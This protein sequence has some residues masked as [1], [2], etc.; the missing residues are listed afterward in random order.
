MIELLARLFAR[1]DTPEDRL[2]RVAIDAIVAGTDP[3]LRAVG[4][5]DKRLHEPARTAIRYVRDIAERLGPAVEL[6]AAIYGSDPRVHALFGSVDSMR[7]IVGR[8]PALRAFEREADRPRGDEVFA[9]LLAER[10]LKHVLG[11]DLHGDVVMRDLAKTLLV[12]AGHRLRAVAGS[13]AEARRALRILAFRQLVA[14][15]RRHIDD[16]R[17]GRP[18]AL[19]AGAAD[20]PA[21][22]DIAARLRQTG[23]SAL[24]LADYL[25]L[26]AGVFARP[27]RQLQARMYSAVVDRMGALVEGSNTRSD[28]DA[29]AFWEIQ[30]ADQDAPTVALRVRLRPEDFPP[31]TPMSEML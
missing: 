25:V 7:Q 4:G 18:I 13:E 8:D 28:T 31:P 12:F 26:V 16:A 21:I 27:E 10:R 19:D 9:L 20:D 22:A 17:A 6:S 29:I 23:S 5:V 1:H 14:A 24:T 30:R 2:I 3:R 15:A 11:M